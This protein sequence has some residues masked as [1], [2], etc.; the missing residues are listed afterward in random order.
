M[1]LERGGYWWSGNP[2]RYSA[3]FAPDS[4]PF[5]QLRE[6]TG[7][8][9]TQPEKEMGM[10]VPIGYKFIL[11]FAA[12]IAAVGFTPD[13]VKRL[14]YSTEM[15]TVLT[16]V[17]AMTVGLILGWFFSRRFTSNISALTQSAETI[18]RG[19]LTKNIVTKSPMFP[20]ETCDLAASIARMQD[21]LRELVG[22]LNTASSK[23]SE[24][25]ST[26]TSSVLEI[27]A[28]TEEVAQ[29][30]EQISRGAENQVEMVGK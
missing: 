30:I 5:A 14:G 4:R 12:V 8:I 27:N 20:D 15:T 28:S 6:F 9:D 22:H 23:V 2:R 21:S 19:D 7:S 29:A 17:V 11:G 18:S 24:S 13:L 26:L 3:P 25:A 16:Y 1:F 10:H